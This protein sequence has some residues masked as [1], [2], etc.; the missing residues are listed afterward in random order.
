VAYIIKI[1]IVI[2]HN[3]VAISYPWI[4]QT[5]IMITIN[6]ILKADLINLVQV[7]PKIKPSQFRK[8]KKMMK[9]HSPKKAPQR[10]L[11]LMPFQKLQ[12]RTMMKTQR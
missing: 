7:I 10:S 3:K 5:S 11:V 1:Q 2:Y 8:I 4:V 9:I 12:M 6:T